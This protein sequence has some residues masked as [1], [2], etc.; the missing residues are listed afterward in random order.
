MSPREP[1]LRAIIRPIPS[2]KGDQPIAGCLE[3]LLREH[4]HIA[5]VRD[6][7]GKV[8]GMVSLED[9]VEELL[10]EIEDEYD[11]L[12]VHVVASGTSWVAGGGVTLERLKAIT[13][14]DLKAIAPA[15]E[16]PTLS[17]WVEGHLQNGVNGGEVIERGDVRVLV[18]KARRKRVQEAQISRWEP[19]VSAEGPQGPSSRK[20]STGQP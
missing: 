18:R 16:A 12:P 5:L 14:L 4:T 3:R 13:G 8:V 7:A 11:R 17:A 9:I 10:G 6:A 15:T 1:T 20:S 19:I 2:F